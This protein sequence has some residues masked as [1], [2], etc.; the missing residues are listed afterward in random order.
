MKTGKLK[1]SCYMQY[2]AQDTYYLLD[3]VKFGEATLQLKS[4]PK[5]QRD[6]E[7]HP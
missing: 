5:Y 7:M 2:T 3:Y 4:Q 6:L 1:P